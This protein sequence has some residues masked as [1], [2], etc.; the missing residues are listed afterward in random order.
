LPGSDVVLL[1]AAGRDAVRDAALE[2]IGRLS[3]RTEGTD[4]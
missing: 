3:L 4:A 2:V 1:W